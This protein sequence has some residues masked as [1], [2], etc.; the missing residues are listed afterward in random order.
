MPLPLIRPLT[1]VLMVMAGVVFAFPTVPAKPFTDAT[2]VEVTVPP[3][4]GEVL[5]IIIPPATLVT[6]IPLPAVNVAL[7]SV[8]PVVFP[9]NNCPSV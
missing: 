2:D 3:F 5:E 8:L 4:D 9:I 7:F 6:E 1:V